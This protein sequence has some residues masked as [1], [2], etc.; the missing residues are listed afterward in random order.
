VNGTTSSGDVD[1]E[2]VE[3]ALLA[4]ESQYTRAEEHQRETY[5]CRHG[6]PSTTKSV[7]TDPS[8]VDGDAEGSRSSE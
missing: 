8:G 5:L 7:R 2:R 3:A 1:S 6:H 4:A